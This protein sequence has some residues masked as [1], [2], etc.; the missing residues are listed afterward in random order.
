MCLTSHTVIPFPIGP[1]CTPVLPPAPRQSLSS[2]GPRP[3]PP[4]AQGL[5][6]S[7]HAHG[8]ALPWCCRCCMSG[9]CFLP[10]ASPSAR[11]PAASPDQPRGSG[12]RLS[13]PGHPH[14]GTGGHLERGG[15]D[16]VTRALTSICPGGLAQLKG[17]ALCPP[18]IPSRVRALRI[19]P[20][21]TSE[22]TT[23]C[24]GGTS[25]NGQV[26]RCA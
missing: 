8:G 6:K 22:G 10:P 11:W 21:Q 4:A 15:C 12:W 1:A 18:W 14:Q 24:Q 13:R 23:Q 3:L 26:S 17:S 2:P 16:R 20:P 5:F 19:Q 9:S 25:M 7:T